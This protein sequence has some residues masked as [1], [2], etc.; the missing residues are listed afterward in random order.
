MT[1]PGGGSPCPFL[2]QGTGDPPAPPFLLHTPWLATQL[3]WVERCPPP[4]K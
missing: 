3:T 1:Q 4:P 2:P